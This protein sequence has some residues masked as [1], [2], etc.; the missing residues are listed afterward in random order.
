[1]PQLGSAWWLPSSKEPGNAH[2]AH[3][4]ERDQKQIL[5]AASGKFAHL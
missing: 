4:S 2:Y 1:M 3:R 5:A